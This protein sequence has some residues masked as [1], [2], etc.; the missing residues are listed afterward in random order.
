MPHGRTWWLCSCGKYGVHQT[1]RA[2]FGGRLISGPS[3]PNSWRNMTRFSRI[4]AVDHFIWERR[5][6]TLR[7]S[8]ACTPFS[9]LTRLNTK[10]SL[11]DVYAFTWIN[12]FV[13]GWIPSP[14]EAINERR[15]PHIW[16]LWKALRNTDRISHYIDSGRWGLPWENNSVFLIGLDCIASLS[17]I[18]LFIQWG[19]LRLSCLTRVLLCDYGTVDAPTFTQPIMILDPI[20]WKDTLKGA[21]AYYIAILFE[22]AEA[23]T[24]YIQHYT[25]DYMQTA[26]KPPSPVSLTLSL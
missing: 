12:R 18:Y 16:A 25:T 5:Y 19:V 4:R 22:V 8:F 9:P 1:K 6:G 17:D 13:T 26:S 14:P 3:S 20:R 21:Q 11:P 10:P 15:F 2:N 7:L 24:H 23:R